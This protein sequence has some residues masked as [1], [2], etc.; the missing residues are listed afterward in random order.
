MLHR[1]GSNIYLVEPSNFFLKI[2]FP[3]YSRKLQAESKVTKNP[4]TLIIGLALIN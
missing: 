3:L 2:C 4:S 1:G